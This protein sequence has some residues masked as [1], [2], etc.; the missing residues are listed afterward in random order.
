MFNLTK[1]NENPIT[2]W[3][4]E[5]R[6]F[7]DKFNQDFNLDMDLPKMKDFT[8]KIEVKDKDKGYLI[9]AEV[10]GMSE[11]DLSVSLKDNALIIEGE[12]KTE[13][14]S[15]EKGRYF[16]EFSYGSFYR[17]IPLEDEVDASKVKASYR[18]G[19]LS[20]EVQKSENGSHKAKKIP[21]SLH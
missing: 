12:R 20:V 18:D 6:N 19:I 16:S 1:R 14:K 15:E 10:P 9:S 17:S 13:S 3:Q 11:K 5:M 21:I 8:P 2:V 4:N 7:F